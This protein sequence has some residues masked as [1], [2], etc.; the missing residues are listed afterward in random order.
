M[1]RSPHAEHRLLR[2]VL[3]HALREIER[4]MPEHPETVATVRDWAAVIELG[5]AAGAV[6][7]G[8]LSPSASAAL[9]AESPL[10]KVM[11]ELRASPDRARATGIHTQNVGMQLVDAMK[12]DMRVGDAQAFA[13]H[14]ALSLDVTTWH[15]DGLLA[16]ETSAPGGVA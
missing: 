14:G 6:R 9:L 12:R 8:E 2:G 15:R 16:L 13:R 10:A 4:A 11:R 7:R 3:Q 1:I 5:I